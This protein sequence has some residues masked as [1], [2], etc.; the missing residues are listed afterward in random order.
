M[1]TLLLFL[2]ITVAWATSEAIPNGLAL[3][4]SDNLNN[5]SSGYAHGVIVDGKLLT[6]AHVFLN[7]KITHIYVVQDNKLIAIS[8]KNKV[9]VHPKFLSSTKRLNGLNP[10][11][12]T[13]EELNLLT[14]LSGL[15][16]DIAF[17]EVDPEL[18]SDFILPPSETFS[19]YSTFAKQKK[20]IE[21]TEAI[22]RFK[23]SHFTDEKPLGNRTLSDEHV[24]EVLTN[25]LGVLAVNMYFNQSSQSMS[26][27]PSMNANAFIYPQ[28]ILKQGHSGSPLAVKTP[29]GKHLI[30]GIS[31]AITAFNLPGGS[32]SQVFFAG[33]MEATNF[34]KANVE[35]KPRTCKNT[36]K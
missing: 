27:E 17:V 24:V 29:E 18:K 35:S 23:A 34:I 13:K 32:Q 7:N 5:A 22:L 19:D 25:S 15:P 9:K 1:K 12:K 28:S 30:I 36:L 21:E 31:S 16:Y 3:L 6:A 2:L 8:L 10:S 4:V 26:M 20:A 33:Q 14:L 11:L